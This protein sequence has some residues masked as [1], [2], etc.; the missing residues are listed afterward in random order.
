M[1]LLRQAYIYIIAHRFPFFN[2][3]LHGFAPHNKKTAPVFPKAAC[4]AVINRIICIIL[5]GLSSLLGNNQRAA[6][7][8]GGNGI[9]DY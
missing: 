6:A 2:T 5:K 9:G 3:I 7:G 1:P 8:N 4:C